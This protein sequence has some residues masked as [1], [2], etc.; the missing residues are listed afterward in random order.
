[1]YNFF[2][3]SIHQPGGKDYGV[4]LGSAVCGVLDMRARQHALHFVINDELLPFAIV[5]I[6]DGESV[7]M[8]VWMCVRIVFAR[9]YSF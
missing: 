2:T 4:P 5:K 9:F 8:V 1:L 3:S 6:P 7:H